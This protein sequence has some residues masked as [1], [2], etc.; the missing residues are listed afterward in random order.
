VQSIRYYAPDSD[1]LTT[2]SADD[3]IVVTTTEPGVIQIKC[4]LPPLDAR[5][6][7]IQILFTAGY[8]SPDFIPPGLKHAIKMM[9]AHLYEQRTPVAFASPSEVPF[10]LR[11]L[12]ES[13]KVGGW[14]A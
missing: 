7:A 8:S 4:D 12:I 6:D 3:Y 1:T 14:S 11:N 5:P 9:A 13:Q 10:G 2:M